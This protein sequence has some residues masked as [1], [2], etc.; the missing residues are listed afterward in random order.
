M[1]H[2]RWNRNLSDGVGRI[3]S[4]FVHWVFG[5][6][7]MGGWGSTVPGLIWWEDM[8]NCF[9]GGGWV[10]VEMIYEGWCEGACSVFR[11][12]GFLF[13]YEEGFCR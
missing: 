6:A 3:Y 8:V 4:G 5:R 1:S 9:S 2:S 10:E 11:F 7:E 13:C 12:I